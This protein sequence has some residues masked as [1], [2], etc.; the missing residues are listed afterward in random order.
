MRDGPRLILASSSP[1][2]ATL[3]RQIGL[4]FEIIPSSVQENVNGYKSPIRLVTSLA[5]EKVDDVATKISEGI[6]VGADT[7]VV[8]DGKQLGK[9]RDAAEAREM[10]RF[11]SGREHCVYTGFALLHIPS[12]DSMSDYEVTRVKF[13][14]LSTDEIDA[15]VKSGS[16]LD[17]AGAYGIQDDFGAVFVERIDGCYYNVVGFPLTKFYLAWQKFLTKVKQ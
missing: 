12:R 3:L 2:R 17:K 8:L 16:C 7:V 13:R 6:I 1:R 14:E 5:R 11:L 4:E 15:Y 10:L 9:P